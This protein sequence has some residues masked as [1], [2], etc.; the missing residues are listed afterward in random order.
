MR[1]SFSLSL[2]LLAAMVT[3]VLSTSC[4]EEKTDCEAVIQVRYFDDTSMAVPGADV[5]LGKDFQIRVDGVTDQH[6][7]FRHTFDLEAILDVTASIDTGE[8]LEGNS[9]IRLRPG[10]TVY[11]TVYVGPPSP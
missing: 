3:G 4:E 8:Y 2:L 5:I 7:E 10:N 6:G 1:K 11:R 9:V